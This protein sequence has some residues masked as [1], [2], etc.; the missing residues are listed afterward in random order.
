VLLRASMMPMIKKSLKFICVK[1]KVLLQAQM[2]AHSSFIIL[3]KEIRPITKIYL[4]KL[5]ELI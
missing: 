3:V 4:K 5:K 1:D 2:M